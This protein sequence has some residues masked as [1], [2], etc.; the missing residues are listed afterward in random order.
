MD[1]VIKFSSY[2]HSLLYQIFYR[3]CEEMLQL[4]NISSINY[5]HA[6][7]LLRFSQCS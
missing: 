6:D 7:R 4:I 1:L 3:A 2:T 5:F